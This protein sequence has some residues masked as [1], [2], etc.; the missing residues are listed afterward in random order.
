MI[1]EEGFSKCSSCGVEIEPE[2][3]AECLIDEA[4]AFADYKDVGDYY[5]PGNCG[6]CDGYH[7][8]VR[9]EKDQLVCACCFELFDSLQFCQFCGDP[10]TDDMTASYSFGCNH[11]DGSLGQMKDE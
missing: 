5:S 1:L 9:T 10:N 4:A 8:V 3:L 6:F 7:T 2:D 11:C